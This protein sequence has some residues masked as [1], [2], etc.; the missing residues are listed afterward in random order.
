MRTPRTARVAQ[1]RPPGPRGSLLS[2]NLAAYEADRLGFLTRLRDE[3]G[4]VARLAP[5]ST[6]INDAA[7]ALEILRDRSGAFDV[8]D[9]FLQQRINSQEM[10]D[11]L[12]P[13]PLL[14]A[15]LRART[16]QGV[17]A[18]L[19]DKLLDAF[20]DARPAS[21]G[22]NPTPVLEQAFSQALSQ[23]YFGSGADN[24]AATVG[25][26]LDELGLIIGNPF[27]LP[28][29]VRSPT[30][31]NIE[32]LYRAVREPVVAA[33]E[34]R[35][36]DP[37]RFHDAAAKM[38][39]SN[40]SHTISRIADMVIGALL[41]GHRVPA[42]GGA[43]LLMLLSQHA[44]VQEAVRAELRA[45]PSKRHTEMNLVAR[46][47]M[48][49]LRLYPPTWMITRTAQTDVDVQGWH[50]KR[51]HNFLISP[52]VIHRDESFFVDAARFLP[53]RWLEY[54]PAQAA[55][56]AFGA[57]IHLCP[58]R[59]L[60]QVLLRAAVATAV[61]N[62][63]IR[64]APGK[65][66]ANPRTTLLPDGLR[67]HLTPLSDPLASGPV[68]GPGQPRQARTFFGDPVSA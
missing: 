4:A 6:A 26:L 41:A 19:A 36:A 13:R 27:A 68:Q 2:G 23:F 31:R 58:G 49:G 46:V 43:W 7:P 10:T 1:T 62:Y 60:A 11:R 22:M 21:G 54:R 51:G 39:A 67:L 29:W 8:R 32:H 56:L 44:D 59:N 16:S 57:G 33:L 50:F 34:A 40:S 9:N 66:S 61:T 18:L 30:R 38:M 65:I 28:A 35:A 37:G 47:V 20:E 15:A 55:F 48:E 14:N 5:R 64:P 25:A 63:N 24:I 12:A 42:A 53:D 3:Y 17:A 52:Y 45:M